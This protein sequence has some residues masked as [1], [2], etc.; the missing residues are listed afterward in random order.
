MFCFATSRQATGCF[1]MRIEADSG[2]QQLF[3]DP[4]AVF[5]AKLVT[6]GQ[7]QK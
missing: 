3:V 5:A 6:H 7:R 2:R 1:F 4:E